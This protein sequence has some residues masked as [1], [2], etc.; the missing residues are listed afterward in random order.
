MI[1]FFFF[2]LHTLL[3]MYEDHNLVVTEL[4]S[5]F[6]KGI[7]PLLYSVLEERGRVTGYDDCFDSH[8]HVYLI[9][10]Q[11]MSLFSQTE[12]TQLEFLAACN[13]MDALV[14]PDGQ[15]I[16]NILLHVLLQNMCKGAASPDLPILLKFYRTWSKL[17]RSFRK[18][19][20]LNTDIPPTDAGLYPIW[21][22]L[23]KAKALL[24]QLAQVTLSAPVRGNPQ[25]L[26]C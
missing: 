5:V 21:A 23:S 16:R 7:D 8:I 11:S 13:K 9:V 12:D 22:C 6:T 3:Q 10:K 24:A 4:P 2:D 17:F 19:H 26:T 1:S 20:S 15:L 25:K 14:S 18:K